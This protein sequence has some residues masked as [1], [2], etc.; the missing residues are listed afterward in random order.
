M[1]LMMMRVD[2]NDVVYKVGY[3]DVDNVDDVGDDACLEYDVDADY[4]GNY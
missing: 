3:V 2:A 4:D 1:T